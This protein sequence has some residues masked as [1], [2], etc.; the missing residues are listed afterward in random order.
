MAKGILGR[1]EKTRVFS[2]E[3]HESLVEFVEECDHCFNIKLS[4]KD[5]A[6]L[7]EELKVIHDKLK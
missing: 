5:L 2:I 7:I 1:L 6:Q 3:V 4:K